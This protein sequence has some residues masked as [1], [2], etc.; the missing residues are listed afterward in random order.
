VILTVDP[1]F[2]GI[3][4]ALWRRPIRS[5]G[6][7]D[8]AAHLKDVGTLQVPDELAPLAVRISTRCHLFGQLLAADGVQIVVLETPQ[9]KTAAYRRNLGD[10][11][12]AAAVQGAMQLNTRLAGALEGVAHMAGLEVVHA[13]AG[14]KK[15]AQRVT[16]LRA[17]LP[18][19]LAGRT[20]EHMRDALYIGLQVLTD[21][22]RRWDTHGRAA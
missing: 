13:A 9:T 16:L 3:G 21:H 10:A 22:R 17:V 12:T 8:A 11:K 14:E 1:G 2:G 5:L 4:W 18:D 6:F 7:T 15:K 20:N 19:A